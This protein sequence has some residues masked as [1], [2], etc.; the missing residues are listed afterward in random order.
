[1]LSH[2]HTHTEMLALSSNLTLPLCDLEQAS[3]PGCPH[4]KFVL[5]M[6]VVQFFPA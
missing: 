5:T 2:T 4:L 6:R 1:M 3:D